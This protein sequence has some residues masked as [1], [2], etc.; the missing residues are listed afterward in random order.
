MSL[1]RI[2][3]TAAFRLA[4]AYAGLFALSTAVPFVFVF[5]AVTDHADDLIEDLIEDEAEALVAQAE[6]DGVDTVAATLRTWDATDRDRP[7]DYALVDATGRVLAGDLDPVGSVAGWFEFAEPDD[8]DDLLLALGTRLADGSLLVVAQETDRQEL[9]AAVIRA[10]AWAGSASLALAVMGGT[11][12]SA[13]FL[14]RLESFNL[15]A[16]GIID[17]RLGERVP[18]RGAGDEFDRLADNLNAM[19]D[20]IQALM[21]SMRQVSNDI[22]HDLRTPL[23]HLRQRLTSGFARTAFFL[24]RLWSERKDRHDASNLGKR[25]CL[26][27]RHRMIFVM[28][29]EAG[30]NSLASQAIND[31]VENQNFKL[32]PLE[33]YPGT[34]TAVGK[35]PD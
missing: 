12:T 9:G 19:L 30:E 22:A 28:E 27:N 29:L 5:V 21:E 23:S 1:L 33:I 6:A 18:K 32:P 20:R 26:T 24:C 31:R 8:G 14:R 13:A 15:T 25:R 35:P 34:A 2:F 16:A 11:I 3:R 17:G 7:A 10:F 4:L